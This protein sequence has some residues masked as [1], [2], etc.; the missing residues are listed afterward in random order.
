M[1]QQRKRKRAKTKP[2]HMDQA[3]WDGMQKHFAEVRKYMRGVAKDRA[4]QE[5]KKAGK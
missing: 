2:W 3:V 1:A 4:K 5:A